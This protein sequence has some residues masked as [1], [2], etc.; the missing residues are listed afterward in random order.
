MMGSLPGLPNFGLPEAPNPEE[1]TS[2]TVGIAD[3]PNFEVPTDINDDYPVTFPEFDEPP[4]DTVPDYHYEFPDSEPLPDTYL[5]DIMLP[6]ENPNWPPPNPPQ[7][8][9]SDLFIVF[10]L[11]IDNP[12]QDF[13]SFV[14]PIYEFYM[15]DM[16]YKPHDLLPGYTDPFNWVPADWGLDPLEWAPW[17][18]PD[19]GNY[20]G[21]PAS[22]GHDPVTYDGFDNGFGGYDS[23]W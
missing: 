15:P 12:P 18:E 5:Y 13:P 11:F 7:D 6:P 1:P 22:Y 10:H 3:E 23:W 20:W 4:P 2:P 8:P 14:D 9:P 17:Q 21:D 19:W 16:Q